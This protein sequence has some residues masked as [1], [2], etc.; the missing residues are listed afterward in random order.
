M[1]K[2]SAVKMS[3][4][5]GFDRKKRSLWNKGSP[6]AWYSAPD[7]SWRKILKKSLLGYI[8]LELLIYLVIYYIINVIYRS[9]LGEDDQE[10]FK[11]MADYVKREISP[12]S[13]DL[14]FLL[15]FYVSL[16]VKRWWDQYRYLP[17]PD[18]LALL[19]TGLTLYEEEEALIISEELLRYQMLSYVLC[20]RR[21]SK[22]ICN[23]FPTSSD[24]VEA[25]LATRK[26]IKMLENRSSDLATIWW[27]PL[28]WSMHRV[29]VAKQNKQIPSD[30]KEILREIIKFRGKLESLESFLHVPI[31]PV[32]RQVVH[33]AVYIYFA[34][35]LLAY[36][37]TSAD[38]DTYFPFFLV[39]KFV[40]FGGWLKVAEALKNPFGDDG[41]DFDI[42]PLISRHIWACG[43]HLD[44]GFAGLPDA[45][46][47]DSDH[48]DMVTLNV[49]RDN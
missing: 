33:L 17:W 42:G 36:Q 38:P 5:K 15:G 4:L 13:R 46:D 22:V 21:I 43:E 2:V 32:Y 23:E 12:L 37:V 44:F 48:E 20:L 34:A 6:S 1:I 47:D 27:L 35:A 10:K 49:D 31:P 14:T 45:E 9:A 26:E 24:L 16:V 41:D 28:Q 30:H 29:K 8:G 3:T 11:N 19:N 25:G 40:F 39:L 18:T 7:L